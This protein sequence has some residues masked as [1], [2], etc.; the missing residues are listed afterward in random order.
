[1]FSRSVACTHSRSILLV[2]IENAN[3][4]NAMAE[5]QVQRTAQEQKRERGGGPL[6]GEDVRQ[7]LLADMLR[8]PAPD[9]RNQQKP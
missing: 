4:E 8:S 3:E 2:D 9:C 7:R 1:M 6:L 5:A